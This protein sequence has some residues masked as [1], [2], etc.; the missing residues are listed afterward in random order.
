MRNSRE[1]EIWLYFANMLL[2]KQFFL[3]FLLTSLIIFH[4]LTFLLDLFSRH[5]YFFLV[6]CAEVAKHH[7]LTTFKQ[8]A[9]FTGWHNAINKVVSLKVLL[10]VCHSEIKAM[11]HFEAIKPQ[12]LV[13][14]IKFAVGYT[15]RYWPW[16]LTVAA[17]TAKPETLRLQFQ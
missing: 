12:E 13:N 15:K 9:V 11:K 2:K 6:F 14:E 3:I 16:P 5:I 4:D 1:N 7:R 8:I 10:A 17:A